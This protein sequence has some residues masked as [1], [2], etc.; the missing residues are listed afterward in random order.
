MGGGV[1]SAAIR[2]S[3][4]LVLTVVQHTL[5]G[6]PHYLRLAWTGVGLDPW[7]MVVCHLASQPAHTSQANTTHATTMQHM[8]LH[9]SNIM[10]MVY[11]QPTWPKTHCRFTGPD[12]GRCPPPHGVPS[13]MQPR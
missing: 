1:I 5:V 11:L 2:Q 8:V 9:H 3:P 12:S 6:V 4:D 7:A 13:W 10:H